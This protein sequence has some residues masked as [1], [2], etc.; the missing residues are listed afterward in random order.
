MRRGQRQPTPQGE[1][2]AAGQPAYRNQSAIRMGVALRRAGVR[3]DHLSPRIVTCAHHDKAQM[4]YLYPRQLADGLRLAKLPG[5]GDME[6][7]GSSDVERFHVRLLGRTGVLY[8]RDYW[9]RESDAPGRPTGDLIDLWNGYR[10][11]ESWL[12]EWMSWAGYRSAYA[13]AREMWFWPV[14]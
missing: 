5:F 3:V 9:R 14:S 12:M 6:L 11:T 4:H 8:V 13:Q 10:T 1:T 2:I 7:I